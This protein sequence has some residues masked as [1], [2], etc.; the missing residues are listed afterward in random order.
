MERPFDKEDIRTQLI[1][2]SVDFPN[3]GLNLTFGKHAHRNKGQGLKIGMCITAQEL[4]NGNL[5]VY[6][7]TDQG[8]KKR[9]LMPFIVKETEN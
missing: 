7:S 6:L 3:G 4:F 8:Y 2:Q 1:P 9:R 5:S